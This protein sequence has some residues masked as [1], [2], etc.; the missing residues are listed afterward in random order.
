M[1]Q[2]LITSGLIDTTQLP[3]E[4]VRLQVSV[5]LKVPL[6]QIERLELWQN[7]VWVKFVEGRGKFVSY[8]QLPL[9]FEQG[10]VTIESCTDRVSLKQLGEVLLVERDW[11]DDSDETEIVQQWHQVIEHWRDAWGKK[12]QA[13]Q[14][15]EE[16][17]KPILTHQQEGKDWLFGWRQVLRFCR[18]CASLN[19]LAPEIEVQSQQF[20]D[21]PEVM[22]EMR[23]LLH[24]RWVEL[25]RNEA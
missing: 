22:Q 2:N 13:I 17:L 6:K 8:R 1:S 19:L 18:D 4:Q 9:W 25:S 15:E 5:L 24:Q 20:L 11:Y 23:Q 10:L 21:L 12:A 16:R 3:L 7:Q 14:R